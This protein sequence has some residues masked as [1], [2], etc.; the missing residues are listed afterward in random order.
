MY[1]IHMEISETR[2]YI[3][4]NPTV[5][6]KTKK[7]VLTLYLLNSLVIPLQL[8]KNKMLLYFL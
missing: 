8:N 7:A 6:Q 1:S 5:Y 3:K 4:K 2:K